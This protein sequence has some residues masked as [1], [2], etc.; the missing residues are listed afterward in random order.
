MAVLIGFTTDYADYTDTIG[1][2]YRHP[3]F[4]HEKIHKVIPSNLLKI[5]EIGGICGSKR[6]FVRDNDKT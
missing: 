3:E 5:C 4:C 2:D 6:W 1:Y